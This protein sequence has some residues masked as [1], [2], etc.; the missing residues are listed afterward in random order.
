LTWRGANF[1]FLELIRLSRHLCIGPILGNLVH[2]LTM[3]LDF[4]FGCSPNCIR[5]SASLATP[6][7]NIFDMP[8]L[9]R[10]SRHASSKPNIII[11][12]VGTDH[13]L[14]LM[15]E[16]FFLVM[17]ENATERKQKSN[18]IM[19]DSYEASWQTKKYRIGLVSSE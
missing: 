17:A 3:L 15:H 14:V 5:R 12:W 11:S 1:R 13:M 6:S 16:L 19:Q 18:T 10:F 9:R 8:W 7:M 4:V 2:Q